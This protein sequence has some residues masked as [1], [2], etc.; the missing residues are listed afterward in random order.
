MVQHLRTDYE[1]VSPY[2]LLRELPNLAENRIPS[3]LK[4]YC[5]LSGMR[6]WELLEEGI[7][8]FFDK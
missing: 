3:C 6:A 1:D 2:L 5:E 4:N 8:Y 7:F